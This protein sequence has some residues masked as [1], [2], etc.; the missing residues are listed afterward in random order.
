M[1]RMVQLAIM[2]FIAF[3]AVNVV[4]E[5][6]HKPILADHV[7]PPHHFMPAAHTK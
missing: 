3:V 4:A 1:G 7:V 5:I 6:A 2:A